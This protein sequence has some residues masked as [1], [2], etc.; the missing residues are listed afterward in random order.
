MKLISNKHG[1]GTVEAAFVIPLMFLLMLILLQPGIV[2]YDYLVMN[3]AA[4]EGVRLAATTGQSEFEQNCI[5]FI[6]HRLSAIPQ[7]SLF[8][9]HN[10]TCS[11]E[12]S[13]IGGETAESSEVRIV[14]ELQPLPLFD[15]ALSLLGAT[16]DAGNIELTV[17]HV[18]RNQP[19]W[20]AASVTGASADWV[21]N[22]TR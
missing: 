20:V 8:H 6:K 14:N 13:V 19:E 3:N 16:N 15:M 12:I 9:V 21:E 1:Q 17:R 18:Q 11:Y 22:W 2:L 7:Q 4:A 10:E 5:E